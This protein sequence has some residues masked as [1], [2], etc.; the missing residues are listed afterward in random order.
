MGKN[1]RLERSDAAF[2]DIIHTCG[3]LLGYGRSHG[4]ADFY[5]NDGR[6]VQP[7]CEGLQ[8]IRGEIF[9]VYRDIIR[10][11]IKLTRVRE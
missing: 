1:C 10:N 4:H 5:P 3:G 7:G 9:N 11:L 2:V 6:A 8:E